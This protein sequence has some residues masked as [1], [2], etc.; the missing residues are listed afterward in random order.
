VV[1]LREGGGGELAAIIG[2]HD[3]RH[4]VASDGPSSAIGCGWWRIVKRAG[5]KI[6]LQGELPDLIRMELVL[7]GQ[8][9][10]D[11]FAPDSG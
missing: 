4:A 9:D 2:V 10:Q 1:A 3:I 11:L 8:L 7:L 5:Q 6:I